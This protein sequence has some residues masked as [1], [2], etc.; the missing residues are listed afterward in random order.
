MWKRIVKPFDFFIITLVCIAIVAISI[1]VYKVDGR[2]VAVSIQSE[3]GLSI[4]PLNQAQ[5]LEVKGPQGITFVEIADK[6][7]R[8]L[9]SPCRDKLCIIKGVLKKNGDWTACMPNRVYI[10]IKGGKEEELDELS[11]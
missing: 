10:G 2:P 5:R 1:R 8:V 6:Q 11:Y 7:V 9:S 4:Y 3:S